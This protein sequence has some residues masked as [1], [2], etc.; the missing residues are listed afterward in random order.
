MCLS[1]TYISAVVYPSNICCLPARP[2]SGLSNDILNF[3]SRETL[4]K[5]DILTVRCSY[6]YSQTGLFLRSVI[7]KYDVFAAIFPPLRLR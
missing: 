1:I 4:P 3:V 7:G 2:F 6:L 5:Y